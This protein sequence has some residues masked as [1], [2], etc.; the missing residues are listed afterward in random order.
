M[1]NSEI[2]HAWI[3]RSSDNGRGTASNIFFEGDTIYSYGYHFAIAK[4][5]DDFIL[6]NKDNYSSTTSKH[7]SHVRSAIS[8]HTIYE[9][10]RPN[11]EGKKEHLENYDDL[12]SDIESVTKQVAKGRNGTNAQDFR[13][14]QIATLIDTAN[15]Y[16]KQF[17]LGKRQIPAFELTD[18]LKERIKEQDR[19]KQAKLKRD[20]AKKIKQW[21]AGEY[22]GSLHT[23][24]TV[25]VRVRGENI[26]TSHGANFPKEHAPIA[27]RVIQRCK[28]NKSEWQSNGHTIKLGHYQVQSIS[29][30]GMLTAGCHKV[31]YAQMLPVAKELGLV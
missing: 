18:D 28:D 22:H 31:G 11:A 17:K 13:L 14:R 12:I 20:K 8:H 23:I 9:V 29:A 16:T 10:A 5:Y 21:L 24:K 26:E 27:W 25:Y 7:L 19:K 3:H 1:N 4:Q 30:K 2:G 15:F 6:F